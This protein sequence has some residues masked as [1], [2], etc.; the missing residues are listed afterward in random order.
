MRSTVDALV[1][2]ESAICRSF[3]ERLLMVCIFFDLEKAYDTT[4]RYEILKQLH[5][6]GLGDACQRLLRG[7]FGERTFRVRV[8]TSY[9]PLYGQQGGVPQGNVLS[10]TLFAVAING[11]TKPL[12]E[13]V[14]SFL[15]VDD[16]A[17]R[18][19]ASRM[20]TAERKL[21]HTIHRI[22]R[23]AEN[24]GFRFSPSKSVDMHFCRIRG[25]HPDPNLTISG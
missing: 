6:F 22:S 10:V 16:L 19:S 5:N 13:G 14:S 20:S 3:A 4:W 23:W 9:S 18:D 11:V 8:G 25:H 12:P 1:R 17:V 24:H 21:L 15:Y 2:L 7:F